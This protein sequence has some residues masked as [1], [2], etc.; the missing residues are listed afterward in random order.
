MALLLAVAL[1]QADALLEEVAA[2]LRAQAA[3]GSWESSVEETGRSLSAMVAGGWTDLSREEIG[4]I[5][6]GS[7]L[8]RGLTWLIRRQR[9]D[10]LFIPGD[11]G[12]NA[13]PAFAVVES[14]AWTGV[15]RWKASARRAAE[16]VQGMPAADEEA[17][18]GQILVLGSAR[19]SD[20]IPR[21]IEADPTPR[22]GSW[23]AIFLGDPGNAGKNHRR[24][25]H[26]AWRTAT[27]RLLK[28]APR[29]LRLFVGMPRNCWPCRNV[30]RKD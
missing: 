1:V 26:E 8:R 22:A 2:L 15:E 24:S 7:A 30:L 21:G 28:D 4:G 13:W 18:F 23:A 6:V 10:G 29:S 14:Y 9:D 25:E 11:P 5:G 27:A 19:W 16:A 3:D 20:L 17:R 12:A